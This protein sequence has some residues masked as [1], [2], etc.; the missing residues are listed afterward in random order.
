MLYRDGDDLLELI[1]GMQS[2]RMDEQRVTLPYLP[3][4]N[5]NPKTQA[6]LKTPVRSPQDTDDSFIDM[7]LR[8]QSS[9]LEDQRSPLP[10]TVALE[11][12]E[13][14]P[15]QRSNGNTQAGTTVP[16]ED[17]FALIQRLQAERMEDQRASGP[18]KNQ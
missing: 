1:A 16:E 4:L 2:K 9:R 11:D 18:S 12:A 13:D 7:L 8:C 15:N 3:G 10:A 6:V 14:E 17:L 5:A